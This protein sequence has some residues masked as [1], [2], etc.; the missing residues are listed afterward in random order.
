MPRLLW[1]IGEIPWGWIL[2]IG[3]PFLFVI[4]AV[5]DGSRKKSIGQM[6]LLIDMAFCIFLPTLFPFSNFSLLYFRFHTQEY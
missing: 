6:I 1:Y 3:I 2:F 4:I 5:A